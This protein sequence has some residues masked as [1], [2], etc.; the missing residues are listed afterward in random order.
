[1]RSEELDLHVERV[2]RVVREVGVD[3]VHRQVR[4]DVRLVGVRGVLGEDAVLVEGE[5]GVRGR[6]LDEAV[7]LAPP[8]AAVVRPPARRDVGLVRLRAEPVRHL[9]DV[10][11]P[12]ARLLQ[13]DRQVVLVVEHAIAALWRGVAH[14]VVV[15]RVLAGLD[16][17]ARRTAERHRDVRVQEVRSLSPD[18][19]LRLRHRDQVA[20]RLVVG[21]EHDH[22][23]LAAGR[24]RALA[25]HE[26]HEQGQAGDPGE[27]KRAPARNAR[28]RRRRSRGAT[29]F[30]TCHP[31]DHN[32]GTPAKLRTPIMKRVAPQLLAAA[33]PRL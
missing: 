25:A 33:H 1:M 27:D 19:R 29:R 24:V 32:D 7:E 20:H 28:L 21:G 22:V 30:V 31:I 2:V 14:D 12:V 16:G 6:G 3:P 17:D 13:P 26:Q 15:V 18:Q 10:D 23:R 5:V 8:G 9:A 11:R 4:V